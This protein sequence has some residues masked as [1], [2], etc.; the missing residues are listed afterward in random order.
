VSDAVADGEAAAGLA[1]EGKSQRHDAWGAP[2]YVRRTVATICRSG[3]AGAAR[4]TL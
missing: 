1:S 4:G 3:A 2:A